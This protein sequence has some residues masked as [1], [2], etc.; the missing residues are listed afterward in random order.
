MLLDNSQIFGI[1]Q[2]KLTKKNIRKKFARAR[3]QIADGPVL[4]QEITANFKKLLKMLTKTD[5]NCLVGTYFPIQNEVSLLPLMEWMDEIGL[6]YALP[7]VIH[8][9]NRDMIFVACTLRDPMQKNSFGIFEPITSEAVEPNILIIPALAVDSSGIRI[10]YGHGYYDKYISKLRSSGKN[11]VVIGACFEQ[12]ISE[13][14]LPKEVHDQA[15]NFIVTERKI[16]R[17]VPP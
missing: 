16:Y 11:L 9:D 10:G 8:Y 1:V 13:N 4:T 6:L 17:C 12:Q 15:L 2:M 3:K 7:K 5:K 14:P